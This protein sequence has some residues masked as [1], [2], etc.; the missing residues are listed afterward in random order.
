MFCLYWVCSIGIFSIKFLQINK[1][2]L[3]LGLASGFVGRQ[4]ASRESRF[5]AIARICTDLQRLHP[6]FFAPLLCRNSRISA[7]QAIPPADNFR[8]EQQKQRQQAK[9]ACGR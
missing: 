8:R 4:E 3:A 2:R 5:S 7:A 6:L 1:V 9:G